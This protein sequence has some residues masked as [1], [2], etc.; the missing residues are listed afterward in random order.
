MAKHPTRK[1][2]KFTALETVY[3]ATFFRNALS[4][5]IIQLLDPGLSLA[6]LERDS[7]SFEVPFNAI[8]VFQHIKFTA[9]DLYGNDG[10]TDNIVD[11]IHV[12]PCKTLTNGDEIPAHFDTGLDSW[13]R[14]TP[15]H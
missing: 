3:G 7:S 2:V 6:Q 15:C 13:N 14:F 8:P 1:A 9:S 12:H 11:S 5:H 10:S 4:R